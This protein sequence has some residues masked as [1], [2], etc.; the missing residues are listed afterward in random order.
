M[1]DKMRDEIMGRINSALSALD[2][3]S[4]S[5]EKNLGNLYGSIMVLR[6]TLGIIASTKD[7]TKE[8]KL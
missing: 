2:K 3:V 5:G 7:N 6:E 4:V 8:N 1:E